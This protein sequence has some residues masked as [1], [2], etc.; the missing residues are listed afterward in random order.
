MK[1]N[2]GHCEM[3]RTRENPRTWR[4]TCAVYT[5]TTNIPNGVAKDHTPVSELSEQATNRLS[6]GAVL[7][8]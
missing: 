3:I 8:E 7:D 6:D 4:K 2:V 5:L 1:T